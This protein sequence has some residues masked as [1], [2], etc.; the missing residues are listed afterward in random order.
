MIW[1][2]I[3]CLVCVIVFA[4]LGLWRGLFKSLF[5]L[6]AWIGGIIGAYAAQDLLAET[7][8]T[9]LQLSGFTVK[10]VC[11]CIGFIVPFLG[12]IFVG[13]MTNKAVSGTAISKVNR[14]LGTILGIIKAYLACFVFLSILHLLPVTGGLK[15]ARNNSVSYSVYKFSLEV[16]GFSS[17]E[18]DL[19]GVAE[20]K[21]TEISKEITNKAV[22]KAKEEV[23]QATE[24]IKKKAEEE[25]KKVIDEGAPKSVEEAKA[26]VQEKIKKHRKKK[27]VADTEG[28]EIEYNSEKDIPIDE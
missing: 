15:D 25:A 10:L 1:I 13:H 16:M 11:I 12:F 4:L 9:N 2:D 6:C 3:V 22:E 8:S 19:I 5:R 28:D 7:I 24:E 23:T 20:K 26:K 27:H 17:K 18:I 14:I 21:A